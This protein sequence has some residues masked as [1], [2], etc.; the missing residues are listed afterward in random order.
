V[1]TLGT[2]DGGSRY[3]FQRLSMLYIGF[4]GKVEAKCRQ[5]GDFE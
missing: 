1:W 2:T 3:I 4:N 5:N